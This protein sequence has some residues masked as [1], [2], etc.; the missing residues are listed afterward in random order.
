MIN[1]SSVYSFFPSAYQPTVPNGGATWSYGPS[2]AAASQLTKMMA[3]SL[4]KRHITVNGILPGYVATPM[5]ALADGEILRKG[6]PSGRLSG[7]V[8]MAGIAVLYASPAG[9]HITGTLTTVDGGM[10][11]YKPEVFGKEFADAFK[12]RK[13]E[14]G[15]SK[16]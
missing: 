13:D 7:P 15:Q 2:K 14:K 11:L 10:T 12:P 4:M 9:A 16:L 8:D 5:T 1:I 6:H 3:T